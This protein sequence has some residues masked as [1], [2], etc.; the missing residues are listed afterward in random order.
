MYYDYQLTDINGRGQVFDI[1]DL[2]LNILRCRI[3][4][5]DL[6]KVFRTSKANLDDLGHGQTVRLSEAN[7]IEHAMLI[8]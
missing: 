6:K 1:Y 4:K 2:N 3:Q 7:L 5:K 8:Y